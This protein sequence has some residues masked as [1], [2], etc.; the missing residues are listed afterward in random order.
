M[1]DVLFKIRGLT[2]GRIPAEAVCS[3]ATVSLDKHVSTY[4]GCGSASLGEP[5]DDLGGQKK[6]G[7]NIR[8]LIQHEN[9]PAVVS[10]CVSCH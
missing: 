7:F 10:S 4:L 1:S 5:L 3:N 9:V 6:P 2:C 8:H